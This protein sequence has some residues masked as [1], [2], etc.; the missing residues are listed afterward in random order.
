[1]VRL[2]RVLALAAVFAHMTLG[3]CLHDLRAQ[4]AA[5][6]GASACAGGCGHEHHRGAGDS[7]RPH[8]RSRSH[9]CCDHERCSFVRP[10]VTGD[11]RV[12]CERELL[13]LAA[14]LPQTTGTASRST[15]DAIDPRCVGDREPIRLHL[16]FQVLLI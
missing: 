10:E 8:E 2:V 11:P 12:A 15:F 16:V 9:K 13:S 4:A 5:G 6:G 3:C 1:M 7:D 14:S